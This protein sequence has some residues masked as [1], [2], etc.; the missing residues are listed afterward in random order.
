MVG[1]ASDVADTSPE[2]DPAVDDSAVAAHAR[3]NLLRARLQDG[4]DALFSHGMVGTVGEV[5]DGR[6]RIVARSGVARAGRPEPVAF[7]SRFRMGSNTKTFVA[8]VML[9][10][11]EEGR[12]RLDDS[13]DHWLPGV[14]SG[15]GNDGRLVTVRNLLQHT[16]G[17]FDYTEALLATFTL[18]DYQRMRFQSVDPEE[19]VDVAMVH[20][21]RFAPGAGWSYSNTNY[22]L[23]GMI[24]KKVTGHDWSSE[25]RTRILAPLGMSQTFDPG[26]WPGLPA[27][28]AS[29]YQTFTDDGP[30]VDVTLFNHT[31]ADAAGA[32][33]TTTR[34]L[35]RFWRALQ[36][37]KLLGPAA[38]AEMHRTI[39]ATELQVV[40][41]GVRYGLG[42][43]WVPAR[44]GAGYW[45]HLGDTFGFSTRNGV[46][47]DGSRAV[48]VSQN[49]TP[50]SGAATLQFLE[51][52][53]QLVDQV[54]CAGR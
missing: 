1:D 29:G 40:I 26:D 43:L 46:S 25:V 37:G 42:I 20:A 17:I 31:L 27:P 35:T 30:L 9:Q 45:G 23:A 24:I 6:D 3:S 12:V 54:M 2:G 8:V 48:V 52:D 34:D 33:V 10:L 14:V 32:L 7:D 5:S 53:L 28:H 47:D 4:L 21:P 39:D 18:A 19:L 44:C 11:V 22:I 13:V 36:R 16:S 50:S 51:D 41:P 15:N 49:T 38:M